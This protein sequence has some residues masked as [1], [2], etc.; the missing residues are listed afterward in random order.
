MRVLGTGDL[1]SRLARCCNPVPG[2]KIIGYVTRG[3][4]VS[5]HR[6]NCKNIL[7][8]DEKAHLNKVWHRLDPWPDA[9]EGLTRLQ[10]RFPVVTL[11]NGNVAL[12]LR[13][14]ALRR[15][16]LLDQRRRP[17]RGLVFPDD[18]EAVERRRLVDRGGGDGRIAN[19]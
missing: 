14:K 7:N 8:E 16:D 15:R 3:E 9:V 10:A 18:H 12:L 17:R 19:R 5:V 4:G 2:D 1:L 11:S 6:R 13:S